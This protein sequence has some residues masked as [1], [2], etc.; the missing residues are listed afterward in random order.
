MGRNQNT[1]KVIRQPDFCF[2]ARNHQGEIEVQKI[3]A[4]TPNSIER[5]RAIV[6]LRKKGNF[7]QNSITFFK[8]V[9]KSGI[10]NVEENYVHCP[11]C[12]GLYSRKLLWKHK[13][14]CPQKKKEK[15]N[16]CPILKFIKYK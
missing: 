13:T 5:K 6:A 4:M 10:N 14:K 3:L 11:F 8:P 16:K 15:M 12:L 2:F 9:H 1:S 7:V